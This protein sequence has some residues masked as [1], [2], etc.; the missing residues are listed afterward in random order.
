MRTAHVT[1]RGACLL[2]ALSLGLATIMAIA[3]PA[4]A[5][6]LLPHIDNL[7]PAQG[8]VG[9]PVAIIG[10]NFGLPVSGSHVYFHGTEATPL[11]WQ[12]GVI[13]TLVPDGAT[14]GPVTV[15]TPA[16]TSNGA[17]FTVSAMPTP[18]QTWYLAEGT[19]AWGFETFILMEN[20]TD[21]DA[22]V[23][24]VYNTTQYGRLPRPTPVNV[25][26]NSRVTLNLNDDLGLD[27]DVS[28]ELRSSQNIVCERAMYWGN[29]V[30][31]T[32]SI[33]VTEPA[34]TWY[35]AEGCTTWPFET[36]V[37]IQNPGLT[38]TA[39]IDI[40]YMTSNG[41]VEKDTFGLGAGQR[42][43]I[44]VFGDVGACDVSTRVVSDQNIV[45]ERSM[46]WNDRR[47]GHDS[48]GVVQ[49]SQNW[50]LA[51][52]SSAWGFQTWLLLQNPN[53]SAAN[54]DLTFMTPVGP[55]PLPTFTMPANSRQTVNVNEKVPNTDTSIEVVC[56]KE[57]IAE[58]SMYW[59]N[60]T[61]QAGHDTIG[62]TSA[63][64]A[65]YLAEGSTAWGFDTYV[66]IQNP[67]DKPAVVNVTY[68][69]NGGPM[70]GQ[71]RTIDANSRLTI[72]VADEL[73]NMDASVKLT[74]D[75]PIMAERAMYWNAR[76]AGHCSI[77][78]A[79]E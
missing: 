51:E 48:I 13:T 66:C 14:T 72:R 15:V 49:P 18:A 61:G 6:P 11:S 31:G 29:R 57:I 39:N 24:I 27:L 5:Q 73:P 1:R 76:G 64:T 17:D 70:A 20:T 21:V 32:D 23:N 63:A 28:T 2:V 44:N 65:I 10:S 71:P 7:V 53:G 35:L 58:R 79:A 9:T 4:A 55:V 52:G 40:T 25:P 45:C 69:T 60:G 47:G 8:L 41:V 62:M 50:Y 54:V 38:T 16:G 42:K 59:D 78:W 74:S 22:T 33:G 75:K 3:I 19:T 43:S 67:N 46:Y 12:D 34:M 26:P 68:L 37:L 77:G 56:D 36:W 30:E